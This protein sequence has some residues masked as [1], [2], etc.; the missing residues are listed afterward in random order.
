[1][2]VLLNAPS[3]TCGD[4]PGSRYNQTGLMRQYGHD[5]D[6]TNYGVAIVKITVVGAGA[7]GSLLAA[8]LTASMNHHAGD[9]KAAPELDDVLLYGR[10]SEHL[11][12][13][14][15]NGL[16][17]TERDGQ[18]NTIRLNV[19]TNPADVAG[20]DVVIVLVKAWATGEACAP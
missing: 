16:Q 17:L 9:P 5:Y 6:S 10:P 15:N 20:S 13:I 19:S 8:R 11:E 4:R 3:F 1:G 12:S 7:M 18:T 2:V 14:R